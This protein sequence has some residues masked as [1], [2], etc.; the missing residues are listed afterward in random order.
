MLLWITNETTIY[1]LCVILFWLTPVLILTIGYL[2]LDIHALIKDRRLLISYVKLNAERNAE[3]QSGRVTY[4][5]MKELY[6]KMDT[7]YDKMDT[8]YKE[9]TE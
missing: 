8:L 7:L 3:E 4:T 5:E 6:D 9:I 1:S 2:L